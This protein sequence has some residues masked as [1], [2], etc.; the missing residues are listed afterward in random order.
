[1]PH[2]VQMEKKYAKKGLTIVAP[3]VQGSSVEA[4]EEMAEDKKLNYTI[5]KSIRGPS[6]SRGIPSMAVFNTK[7]KLIFVGHPMSRDAEKVVKDALKEVT[8]TDSD[9]GSSSIFDKPKNLIEER[10]WTNSE[11]K[12]IT[13]TLVS[14]EGDTGHFKFPNGKKFDYDITKLSADD[15]T[16]IKEASEKLTADDD[17]L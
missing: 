13:A 1:M 17:D 7:G 3:E 16:V 12:A 2:L 11:G 10:S 6:L 8:S 14:L 9:S 5:T 4:I 15:Q